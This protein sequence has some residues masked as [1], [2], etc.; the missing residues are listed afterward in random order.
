MQSMNS[1]DD[2]KNENDN[3]VV[4]EGQRYKRHSDRDHDSNDSDNRSSNFYL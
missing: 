1:T 3:D 2:G 4:H